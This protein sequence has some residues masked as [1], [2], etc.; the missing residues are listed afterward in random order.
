MQTA[1]LRVKIKSLAEEARII[2]FE[3]RKA[4][5]S[6]SWERKQDPT[7]TPPSHWTYSSLYGHR[8]FDVRGEARASLLAYGFLRGVPYEAMEAT[9][10]D[11]NRP[12][13]TRVESIAKKF[14]RNDFD[15]EKFDLWMGR[16]VTRKT[17]VVGKVI[18]AIT[19]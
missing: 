13:W 10:R 19:R 14:G 15:Q 7:K 4:L 16:P 9:C 6:M 18:Q 3:E 5:R 1:Q 8:T 17:G 11:D 2:R 12:N